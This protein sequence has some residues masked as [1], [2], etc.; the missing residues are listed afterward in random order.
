MVKESVRVKVR[1]V[2]ENGEQCEM[3]MS[4]RVKSGRF[5]C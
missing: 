5:G 3:A 4:E 2:G 1:G